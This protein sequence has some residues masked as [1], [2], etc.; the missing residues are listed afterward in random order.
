MVHIGEELG[1]NGKLCHSLRIAD[2]MRQLKFCSIA[3]EDTDLITL[4]SPP[5]VAVAHTK[6][7]LA[8]LMIT[9]IAPDR[10][11]IA[12][13]IALV[14]ALLILKPGKTILSLA[15]LIALILILDAL[16]PDLIALVGTD[17]PHLSRRR[18]QVI[19]GFVDRPATRQNDSQRKKSKQIA[20][21]DLVEFSLRRRH[22]HLH[23]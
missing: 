3:A 12:I 23:F 9:G 5:A 19:A 11:V 22:T 20:E 15:V 4:H 2:I 18:S 7:L 13:R 6:L 1:Y 10:A 21:R 8:D 17:L 16:Q 14:S